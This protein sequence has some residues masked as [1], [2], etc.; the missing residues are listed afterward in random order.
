M[1]L[2]KTNKQKLLGLFLFGVFFYWSFPSQLFDAP[3]STILNDEEGNLLSAKIAKDGQWRFPDLDSVPQALAECIL[4]FEDEYFYAHPGVNPVSIGRAI[5][6]NVRTGRTVSGGSTITMQVL[7][8]SRHNPPRRYWE[9]VKEMY[10]AVRMEFTYSKTEILNLYVSHAPYGGNVV[11]AEA[12]SWRYFNRP[13]T[14]LSWAEY[15]TLAVLPNAPA[16]L[17]PGKN[18]DKLRAKRDRLL[19]KLM[20]NEVIDSSTYSLS[21]LED[22]PDKPNRLPANAFHV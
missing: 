17:R 1:K 14:D 13:L 15:A 12:A 11:G 6:Q 19:K 20:V 4:H 7:R 22:L 2:S 10:M 21:L 5:E 18:S 9:K 16:L 3:Y 8:M